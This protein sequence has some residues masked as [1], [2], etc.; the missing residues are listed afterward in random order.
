LEAASIRVFALS[1]DEVD[2]RTSS[3]NVDA[4]FIRQISFPHVAGRADRSLIQDFQFIHDAFITLTTPLPLP[5]SFLIDER[6][7]VSVIY[8]GP[9]NLDQ[10]LNDARRTRE[11]H[12]E[13]VLAAAQLPGSLVGSDRVNYALTLISILPRQR[14]AFTLT[15]SGRYREAIAH[16]DELVTI[17]PDLSSVRFGLGDAHLRQG[18]IS[19]AA[20]ALS[21]AVRIDPNNAE[22]QLKLALA[23]QKQKE[24]RRAIHHYRLGLALEP[25]FME[26]AN[27]LAWL[28]AT[29]PDS[30]LRDPTAAIRWAEA[31]ASAT[32]HRDPGI[33]DSLAAAYAEAGQFSDAVTW[34]ARAVELAPPSRR[35]RYVSRLA[36]YRLQRPH[37]LEADF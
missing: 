8:K 36:K 34:Q 19:A 35:A 24:Y 12:S 1:I 5:T 14:L 7:R 33:L 25:S 11:T 22:A 6:G 16:F 26:G 21:E 23:F 2:D 17:A 4:D 18:H 37:R 10:L 13:R 28:L 9:L 27:N 15:N 29:V 32:N 30:S 3:Q 31:C 20:A